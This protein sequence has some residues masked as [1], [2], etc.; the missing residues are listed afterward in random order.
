MRVAIE[1]LQQHAGLAVRSTLEQY[2][3]YIHVL[4]A[5]VIGFAYGAGRAY[6]RGYMQDVTP[7]VCRELSM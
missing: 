3:S 1:A 4:S 7:S 6:L 2:C 5:S